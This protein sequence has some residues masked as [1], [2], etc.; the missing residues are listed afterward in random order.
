MILNF[1]Q[2][3]VFRAIMIAKSVSGAAEL[4]HVSQ[5]GISRLLKYMEYKLGFELFERQKGKLIPTPEALD[6]HQE[7]E[8]LYQ[9]L[10]SLDLTISRISQSNDT[11]FRV[12]CAPSLTNHLMPS[13]FA[14]IR[15]E[16][17]GITI[18]LESMPNEEM[19]KHILNRQIDFALAFYPP[20]HPLL[21]SEPSIE[22]GLECVLPRDHELADK[23]YINFKDLRSHELIGYYPETLLGSQLNKVSPGDE[24]KLNISIRVR[25]AD[26]A[27]TLVEKGFGITLAFQYTA[28][29]ERYPTL[30]TIP[31][32]CPK[33]RLQFIRHG[34]LP[35][36]HKVR[37]FYELA[38]TE[39]ES[40]VKT[41]T[42][43][44]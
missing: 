36:S 18:E 14:R 28:L 3:E 42:S 16:M 21:L 33:Q 25:Y 12:A 8:P 1:R 29:P 13:L 35:L 17:P 39:I 11:L 38:K 31:V 20:Q 15:E 23:P 34:S 41:A 30:K 32:R 26:D 7:L 40:V 22:V 19:A 27:C 10:E 2:L 43:Q 9:G 5:P 37:S 44:A 6:L 24:D 4:L